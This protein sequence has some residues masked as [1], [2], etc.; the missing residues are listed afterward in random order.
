M[1]NDEARRVGLQ[2]GFEDCVFDAGVLRLCRLGALFRAINPLRFGG[3]EQPEEFLEVSLL[4]RRPQLRYLLQSLRLDFHLDRVLARVL[5]ERVAGLERERAR[6]LADSEHDGSRERLGAAD[7]PAQESRRAFV[8]GFHRRLRQDD[9]SFELLRHI[10]FHHFEAALGL[11]LLKRQPELIEAMF[12]QLEAIEDGARDPA[13]T[14]VRA[15]L[16]VF[17][18]HHAAF[19]NLDPHLA[20]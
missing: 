5:D 19:R 12:R 2:H 18:D 15:E 8:L 6:H 4:D 10:V 14:V 9:V 17:D 7:Q 13:T 11:G 20:G 16:A 3:A 1:A